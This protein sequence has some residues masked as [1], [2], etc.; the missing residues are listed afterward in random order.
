M[1]GGEDGQK[2][3]QSKDNG[4]LKKKTNEQAEMWPRK[5]AEIAKTQRQNCD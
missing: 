2:Q 3:A 4:E 1:A 5:R